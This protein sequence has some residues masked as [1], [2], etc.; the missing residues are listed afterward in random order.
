MSEIQQNVTD[1]E[2]IPVVRIV[3]TRRLSQSLRCWYESWARL[4]A[5]SQPTV[6]RDTDVYRCVQLSEPRSKLAVI[7][8]QTQYKERQGHSLYHNCVWMYIS[9]ILLYS[10]M[11]VKKLHKHTLTFKSYY[12]SGRYKILL[13]C[14][15]LANHR[16]MQSS[17]VTLYAPRHWGRRNTG[18]LATAVVECRSHRQSQ[19]LGMSILGLVTKFNKNAIQT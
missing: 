13:Y 10:N 8:H 19:Q 14:L 12:K 7:H 2:H 17:K 16:M 11:H 6:Y 1:R 4:Y 18:P 3:D 15:N 9:N 5:W